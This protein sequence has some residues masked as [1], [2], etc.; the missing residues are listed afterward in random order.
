MLYLVG[1][2][3]SR[4]VDM[5]ELAGAAF[6][7]EGT[8][9]AKVQQGTGRWSGRLRCRRSERQSGTVGLEKQEASRPQRNVE[10][11]KSDFPFGGC[12]LKSSA[13][14]V[15]TVVL[16]WKLPSWGLL[17]VALSLSLQ[18]QLSS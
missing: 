6:W 17:P 10:V 8:M 14:V 16:T 3:D 5:V 9:W 15:W 12:V 1:W 2:A 7:V 18:L 13:S 11:R 4:S